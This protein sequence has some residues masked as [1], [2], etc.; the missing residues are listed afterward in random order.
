MKYLKRYPFIYDESKGIVPGTFDG[1]YN[2]ALRIVNAVLFLA[3]RI[4]GLV[5]AGLRASGSHSYGSR[6]EVTFEDFVGTADE[7]LLKVSGDG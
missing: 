4:D 7:L 6:F 5:A 3:D 2:S 1:S